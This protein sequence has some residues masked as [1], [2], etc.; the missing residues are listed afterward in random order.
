MVNLVQ[1]ESSSVLT[2]EVTI[3]LVPGMG[4]SESIAV[5]AGGQIMFTENGEWFIKKFISGKWVSKKAIKDPNYKGNRY[6]W[7]EDL[8]K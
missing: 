5:Q 1:I 3:F 7:E 4:I 2:N 6:I 8:C